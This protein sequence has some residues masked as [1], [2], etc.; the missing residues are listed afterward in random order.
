MSEC[1]QVDISL[2]WCL[3]A[4]APHLTFNMVPEMEMDRLLEGQVQRL[5]QR[6]WKVYQTSEIKLKD[7]IWKRHCEMVE[8]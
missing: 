8:E 3:S 2:K 6:S 1:D 4:P 5:F 7:E